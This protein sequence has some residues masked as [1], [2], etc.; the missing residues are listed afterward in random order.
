MIDDDDAK[1][2]LSANITRLLKDRG[3]NQK[4]LSERTEQTNATIS[5]TVNG[6][7]VPGAVVLSRIAEALDV[8]I[9][10]LLAPP[11]AEKTLAN[12]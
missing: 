5:R 1:R 2:N 9:D 10:R 11:P 6:L 3:W 12:S 4:E 8:S 7:N